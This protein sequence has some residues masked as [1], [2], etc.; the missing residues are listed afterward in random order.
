MLRNYFLINLLLVI[1]I[2]VLGLKLYEVANYTI[3]IPAA[4]ESQKE[5]KVKPIGRPDRLNNEAS[6]GVISN[7]DLF[8]P[9]RSAV[10]KKEV[11]VEKAPPKDPPKLFGTVILND[12]KTAIL[13]DP[14]TKSTKT[15]SVNDSVA[16]YVISDILEDKV[17]LT[18]DGEPF[19]VKL[20]ESKGIQPKRKS[21]SRNKRKS[22]RKATKS[23]QRRPKRRRAVPPRK[24][25]APQP[26]PEP[27]N[28][29]IHDVEREIE[30]LERM[31]EDGR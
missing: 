28:I 17:V 29:N 20:R 18:R 16:G 22:S 1:V 7:L 5:R 13:E 11:K 9:S 10:V 30:E 19:E 14:E 21:I 27:D 12:Y 31:A 15:Y 8:R 23:R 2:A 4:S 6:Y 26:P 3:A 24:S 25:R